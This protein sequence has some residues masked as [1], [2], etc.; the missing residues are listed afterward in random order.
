MVPTT[1]A[2]AEAPLM[3][4]ASNKANIKESKMKKT[5]HIMQSKKGLHDLQVKTAIM[6]NKVIFC[7]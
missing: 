1:S 4:L 2:F 3:K 6:Q 5:C 7:M